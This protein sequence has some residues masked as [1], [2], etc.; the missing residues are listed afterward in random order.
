MT[1]EEQRRGH[2]KISIQG[3]WQHAMNNIGHSAVISYNILQLGFMVEGCGKPTAVRAMAAG[4]LREEP[5]ALKALH[6]E[7]LVSVEANGDQGGLG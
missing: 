3:K 6:M 4:E 2:R 1:L 5:G 7:S